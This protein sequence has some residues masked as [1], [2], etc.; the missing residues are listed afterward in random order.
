MAWTDEAVA[1]LRRLAD[2][3]RSARAIAAALG[4]GSRNAVIGKANRLGVRLNDGGR[5]AASAALPA[6]A[7]VTVQKSPWRFAGAEVG[8][9]RR[10][11]FADI[12]GAVCRWPIGDPRTGDFA[13]CGLSPADGRP[14]CA[15]HCRIAYRPPDARAPRRSDQRRWRGLRA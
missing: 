10:V 4:L 12:R 3:G 14:Y 2:E 9:M 5:A 15:G 8:E 11:A 13:Y 1:T 7:S 6:A